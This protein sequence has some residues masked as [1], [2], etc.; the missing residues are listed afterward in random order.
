M[1]RTPGQIFDDAW[2]GLMGRERDKRDIET[3]STPE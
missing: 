3:P 2:D 1:D